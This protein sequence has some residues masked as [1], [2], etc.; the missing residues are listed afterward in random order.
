M[1]AQEANHQEEKRLRT[2]AEA[3]AK[4]ARVITAKV[5]LLERRLAETKKVAERAN[6]R[7]V[8]AETEALSY[9]AQLGAE[10]SKWMV[11]EAR[12]K[13]LELY[14]VEASKIVE[15]QGSADGDVADVFDAISTAREES[16]IVFAQRLDDVTTARVKGETKARAAESELEQVKVMLKEARIDLQARE[17]GR[18]AGGVGLDDGTSAALQQERDEALTLLKEAEGREEKIKRD[19]NLYRTAATEA[20]RQ[21]VALTSRVEVAVADAKLNLESLDGETRKV[22]SSFQ[23]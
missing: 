10:T 8:A 5:P 21:L 17:G 9:S 2:E 20:D 19:L 13:E 22:P 6:E 18:G 23:P 4:E 3:E 15:E 12:V 11:A 7:A 14:L 16:T 1:A